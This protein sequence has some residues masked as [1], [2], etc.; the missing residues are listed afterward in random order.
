MNVFEVF[1]ESFK[2]CMEYQS[3]S[4]GYEGWRKVKKVGV[5]R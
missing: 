3:I 2:G 5:V 4:L 1:G